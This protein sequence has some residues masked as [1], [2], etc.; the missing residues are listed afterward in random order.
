VEIPFKIIKEEEPK[1]DPKDVH[2]GDLK[3]DPKPVPD[4]DSKDVPKDK[5]NSEKDS[6]GNNSSENKADTSDPARSKGEI[7]PASPVKTSQV[8]VKVLNTGSEKDFQGSTYSLLKARG[9]AKTSKSIKLS[10]SKVPEAKEYIIYGNKCGKKNKYQ[11]IT[12]VKKTSWTARKLNKKALKKNTYYKFIVVAVR[13]DD[14]LAVSKT[15]HVSTRKKANNTGIIL[16]KGKKSVKSAVSVGTGKSVTLKAALKKK[17]KVKIHRKVAWE[18][19]DVSIAIVKNGKITGK[20]AG[21]CYI[22]A[23]AQNGLAKR[24]K[25]TVKD[26]H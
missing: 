3:D 7:T 16:K 25:V 14:I 15:I 4:D 21:S 9:A 6:S 26:S 8:D 20:K 13:D 12:S 11:K 10:W 17:G 23:Y 1:D 18:S 2:E 24:I 5:D 19:S 22:Y